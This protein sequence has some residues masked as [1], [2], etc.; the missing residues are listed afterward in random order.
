LG[1]LVL[2]LADGTTMDIPLA[3]ERVTI[4]RRAD[5]D[6]CLPYPAV[7]GEH[8]AVTTILAD[9]FLEDLGSTNGTLVNG[10][11][12]AKHFL[13]DHDQIDIGRQRL[14]Y[15]SDDAAK[16]DP[17]PPD[18]ARAQMRG[19]ADKVEPAR[20]LPQLDVPPAGD[21]RPQ[22][23]ARGTPLLTADIERD[24]A[25]A[26]A[27]VDTPRGAA[28]APIAAAVPSAP[29]DLAAAAS[30]ETASPPAPPAAAVPGGPSVRVLSGASLGR[31]VPFPDRELT[32]GRVGVQVAAVRK[33]E[34][35]YRLI[36]LEG[37][38]P[39]RVNGA[40]VAPDGS[41]LHPGDTFEIAGVRLELSRPA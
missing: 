34:G 14:T 18:L 24:G 6:V 35:G 40:P 9:S 29:D 13:V 31:V 2:Y 41:P 25:L 23:G 37:R 4:G 22:F 30:A 19:L 36:P 16:A 17:L 38:E 3:K 26:S 32:I 39:P 5:N 27:L 15:L 11:A 28:P 1:K 33:V 7:S 8:A 21:R 12:I 10:R 20:P